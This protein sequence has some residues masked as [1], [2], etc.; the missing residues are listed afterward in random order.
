MV[1]F[2]HQFDHSGCRQ[3]RRGTAIVEM[4]DN[5]ISNRRLA[6][7]YEGAVGNGK[8]MLATFDLEKSLDSRPVARQML[9][10]I[11]KYMNSD[12]FTPER[13]SG[14]EKMKSIFGTANNKKQAA[15]GI[16]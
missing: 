15:E 14:F 9:I 13:L 4:V 8:L 1:G 3:S 11:L 10:S 16:Y 7:L 6:S 2:E 5:F 12:L